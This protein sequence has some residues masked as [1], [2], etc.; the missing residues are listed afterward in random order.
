MQDKFIVDESEIP[1]NSHLKMAFKA[2]AMTGAF[3]FCT[4]PL[5]RPETERP[6]NENAHRF[7]QSRLQQ[8]S[9]SAS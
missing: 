6:P 8:Y 1:Q 4:S 7:Y 9:L 3:I 2:S 5:Q